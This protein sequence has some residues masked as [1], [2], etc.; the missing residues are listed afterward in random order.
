[1]KVLFPLL[2]CFYYQRLSAQSSVLERPDSI[3]QISVPKTTYSSL[4]S[5]MR[6]Y[7]EKI[8]NLDE[9]YKVVYFIRTHFQE[10]SLRLRAAFIWITDNIDYDVE[11]WLKDDQAA[12][13]IDYAV[14]KKKAI[15]G[16]YANL[17]KYFCDKFSIENR[18]I[19]GYARTERKDIYMQQ[20]SLRSNHAWNLVKIN[21]EWRLLDP[22]WAA[23]FVVEPEIFPPY[24]V[25]FF[26][27]IYYFT[28]PEKF[29]LNHYPLQPPMQMLPKPF[30]EKQYMR[31]PMFMSNYLTENIT[32][33]KPDSVHIRI[34][35]G[36]SIHFRFKTIA[37]YDSMF[38]LGDVM[39]KL[40]FSD[41][42]KRDGDWI[43]F[44]Y[45]VKVP[46]FYNLYIG[47]YSKKW[48][49]FLVAYKIEAN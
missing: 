47:Y 20:S 8:A 1:M 40:F 14:K 38:A 44:S 30:Q 36:D 24:Y 10:D 32:A 6:S 21:R 2:L 19:N 48:M 9:L 28:P 31:W 4:D 34:K 29:I 12:G 27:E 17:L 45:P 5:V 39:E 15:C 46:G 33:I 42:Q 22:T 25:K 37:E 16:G 41:M 3:V 18:V 23:G 35:K 26:N 11:A 7:H 13:D 49:Y 43:E